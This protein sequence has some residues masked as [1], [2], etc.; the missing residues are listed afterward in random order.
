LKEL[1][2]VNHFITIL[3][4]AGN[5]I[6]DLGVCYLG[7]GLKKHPVNKTLK[8]LNLT[9]NDITGEGADKLY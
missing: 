4:L 8:S 5:F 9:S 3:N 1:L 2:N 7:E 6:G